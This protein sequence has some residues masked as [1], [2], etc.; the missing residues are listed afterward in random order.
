M[1]A[2]A[3]ITLELHRFRQRR[4]ELTGVLLASRDGLLV[5]SDLPTTEAAHVAALAAA[6]AGLGHR[7]AETLWQGPMR[8]YVVRAATGC[9]VTY[10]AGRYALLTLLTPAATD[11]DLLRAEAYAVAE[12]AGA[13][14]DARWADDHHDRPLRRVDPGAPLATRTPM[15][16]S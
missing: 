15:A 5:A 13:V 3:A 2:D 9:V 12:R 4:P 7:F 11:L 8:E 1:D 6:S 10:P 14:F 16:L